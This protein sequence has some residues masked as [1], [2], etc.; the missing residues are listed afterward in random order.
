MPCQALNLSK[1]TREVLLEKYGGCHISAF[2]GDHGQRIYK[3]KDTYIDGFVCS[4][5]GKSRNV[6][7]SFEDVIGIWPKHYQKKPK[8]CVPFDDIVNWARET[9]EG[10][11]GEAPAPGDYR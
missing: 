5:N 2:D 1:Q 10:D 7:V 4:A 11:G 9:A 8:N 6:R 3:V